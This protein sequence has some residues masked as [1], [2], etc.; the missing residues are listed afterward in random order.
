MIPTLLGALENSSGKIEGSLNQLKEKSI[1]AQKKRNETAVRQIE[2]AVA[3]VLPG[4]TLQ[5]RQINVV[6]FLNKY[7]PDFMKW[8]AGEKWISRDTSTRCSP[9]S[10][11]CSCGPAAAQT[12]DATG[13]RSAGFPLRPWCF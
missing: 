9:S 6:Y 1:A 2:R 4:G 5:E 12:E 7:G 13:S 11:S 8:L 3:S 10:R